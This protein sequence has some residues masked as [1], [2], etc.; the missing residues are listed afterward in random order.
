MNAKLIIALLTFAA[1]FISALVSAQVVPS[2]MTKM[3]WVDTLYTVGLQSLLMGLGTFVV[4]AE[5]VQKV[6]GLRE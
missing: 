1:T 5:P 6:L 2:A 4:T 3:A